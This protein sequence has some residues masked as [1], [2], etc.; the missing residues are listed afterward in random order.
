MCAARA[1]SIASIAAEGSPR[2]ASSIPSLRDAIASRWSL[3]HAFARAAVA[4]FVFGVLG[5]VS[6]WGGFSLLKLL[7]YIKEE[8]LITLGASSSDAAL[9][10]RVRHPLRHEPATSP[11]IA[12][13]H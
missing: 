8:V 11:A 2:A 1:R 6:R 5:L 13:S 3:L 10:S 12:A 4:I 9:P 7:R